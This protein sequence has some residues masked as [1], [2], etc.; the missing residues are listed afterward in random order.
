[1]KKL[2]EGGFQYVRG[3]DFY[4]AYESVLKN[5]DRRKANSV[6]ML[7]EIEEWILIM[8]HYCLIA[9]SGSS[10]FL[11]NESMSQLFCSAGTSSPIGFLDQKSVSE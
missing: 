8:K 7:D 11:C 2:R 4:D 5:E 6:E 3:C 1:M 10:T 9:A